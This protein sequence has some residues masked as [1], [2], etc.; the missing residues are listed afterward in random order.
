[1]SPPKNK[2][3][4]PKIDWRQFGRLVIGVDEVGRG[5]LAG[6]VTAAACLF[7]KG[8]LEDEVADSKK[9]TEK[10]REE[11]S[12]KILAAHP[13]HIATASVDEI[14]EINILKASLLA[15]KRAVEGLQ[16]S[17][18]GTPLEAKVKKA[19]IVVDGN[20][21]IPGLPIGRQETLVQGDDR[22]APISAASIIAKVSRDRL[23]KEHSLLYPGYGF[24]VHKGYATEIHRDALKSL[25]PCVI[26]RKSFM[27]IRDQLE[28]FDESA[29]SV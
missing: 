21:R 22:C 24:E 16:E 8:D 28:L 15:M 4:L 2:I 25:G 9:L 13:C 1:M 10:K 26:H 17:L 7:A 20:V 19:V 5:C 23:M 11:L 18:A 29:E 3:L 12:A 27:G 14:D 6:P